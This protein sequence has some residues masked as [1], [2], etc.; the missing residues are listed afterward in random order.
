MPRELAE[1]WRSF[2][3]ELDARVEHEVGC[4]VAA[5]SS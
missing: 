4:I 5:G 2:L 1:P 3:A